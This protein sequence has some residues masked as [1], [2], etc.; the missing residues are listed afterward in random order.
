[1]ARGRGKGI[2]RSKR[3]FVQLY[4]NVKRSTAYHGLS[5]IARAAL[6]EIID[7]Y[8]GINNGIIGLSVRE[9]A[10]E[11]NC[12]PASAMRALQKLDDAGLA[13]PTKVGAW[14]GKRATEWRLMWRRCDKSGDLPV[15]HWDQREAYRPADPGPK[16]KPQ[17]TSG[18]E[19]QRRY[20][21]RHRNENRNVS[22]TS[23]TLK[24]HQ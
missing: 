9:L 2:Q 17:P 16:P 14:R 10:H 3:Q 13:R 18:A 5:C 19:R 15:N 1:M 24:F 7:R 12:S 8:N 22:F 21:E 6:V 11:L 20:R 4:R 23:E